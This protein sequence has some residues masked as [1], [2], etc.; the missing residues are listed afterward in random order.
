M[1]KKYSIPKQNQNNN[2]DTNTY[3]NIYKN[4]NKKDSNISPE[5]IPNKISLKN[6]SKEGINFNNLNDWGNI[7]YPNEQNI[8]EYINKLNLEQNPNNNVNENNNKNN[9]NI[10]NNI[11]E[12]YNNNIQSNDLLKILKEE[13]N[14]ENEDDSED[15]QLKII[16]K[17]LR[18]N[19]NPIKE[20]KENNINTKNKNKNIKQKVNDA[21]INNINNINDY[22]LATSMFTNKNEII[23][24]DLSE[25]NNIRQ[26]FPKKQ[27]NIL[28]NSISQIKNNENRNYEIKEEINEL[29]KFE[30]DSL[31]EDKVNINYE[32][33]LNNISNKLQENQM[34]DYKNDN[35]K[36]FI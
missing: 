5:N 6:K 20:N 2:N 14:K 19:Y 36:I 4:N 13:E 7:V 8:N 9:I 24:N 27:G 25:N 21:H 16:Q 17:K 34:D 10:N 12:N 28:F 15:E 1:K 33:N 22:S 18:K 26:N 11:N 35:K 29:N 30:K 3:A 23:N 32:N 31:D